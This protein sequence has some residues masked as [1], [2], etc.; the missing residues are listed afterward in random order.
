MFVALCFF[1]TLFEILLHGVWIWIHSTSKVIVCMLHTG[2][3]IRD[4]PM[5]CKKILSHIGVNVDV[6]VIVCC[7]KY[8]LSL[9]AALEL[10]C[11]FSLY[12]PCS[13]NVNMLYD[14]ILLLFLSCT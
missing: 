8:R 7:N 2:V 1:G 3:M 4:S 5:S 6:V 13:E 14:E 11:D 10:L 9:V 12:L